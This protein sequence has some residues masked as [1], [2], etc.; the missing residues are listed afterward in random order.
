MYT[1]RHAKRE[2]IGQL[3]G[4]AAFTTIVNELINPGNTYLFPWLSYIAPAFERYKFERLRFIYKSTCS[5]GIAGTNTNIG[6]VNMVYIDNCETPIPENY[7]VFRNYSNNS[8]CRINDD[9]TLIVQRP[10]IQRLRLEQ[11]PGMDIISN[12]RGWLFNTSTL[13]TD[14]LSDYYIGRLVIAMQG[15]QFTDVVGELYVDY[16][17]TL[18]ISKLIEPPPEPSSLLRWYHINTQELREIASVQ[19]NGNIVIVERGNYAVAYD[20]T[21]RVFTLPIGGGTFLISYYTEIY[22]D[23]ANRPNFGVT[24]SNCAQFGGLAGPL[25]APAGKRT[26]PLVDSSDTP[27][28]GLTTSTQIGQICIKIT[29]PALVATIAF[30]GLSVQPSDLPGN[31]TTFVS[32]HEINPDIA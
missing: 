17:V 24:V 26:S 5:D 13:Q 32:F 20:T 18:G 29:N 11:I 15:C 14:D 31:V 9:Q 16:D 19:I 21:T 3:S 25:V 10:L 4:A 8:S 2:Y 1:A 12:Q 28:T 23:G 27:V 6:T 7:S 30:Y 22:G